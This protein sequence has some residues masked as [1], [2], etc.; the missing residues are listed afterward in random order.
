MG[1]TS[2]PETQENNTLTDLEGIPSSI[3]GNVSVISGDLV[4]IERDITV[5]SPVPLVYERSWSDKRWHDNWRGSVHVDKIETKPNHVKYQGKFFGPFNERFSLRAVNH[6]SSLKD[7]EVESEQFRESVTNYSSKISG[8]NNFHNTRLSY[9]KKTNPELMTL[10]KGDR[11]KLHF[12]GK[13]YCDLRWIDLPNE[14]S[15]EILDNGRNIKARNR[16]EHT[17]GTMYLSNDVLGASDQNWCRFINEKMTYKI[18]EDVARDSFLTKVERSV[19]LML[20]MNIIY[21]IITLLR[22]F[23]SAL[24]PIIDISQSIIILNRN[25]KA[26]MV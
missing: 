18:H 15:Y 1:K 3:V 16:I 5:Q 9:D 23:L 4:L 24:F 17:V 11:T 14:T 8:K 2:D 10:I 13:Y 6:K 25:I 21:L 26:L 7:C 19:F 20:N 22:S 12:T